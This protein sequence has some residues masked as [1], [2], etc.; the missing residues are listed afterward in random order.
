MS[1]LDS[2]PSA[3]AAYEKGARAAIMSGAK[4]AG[5][6]GEIFW[7]G[8]N[9][10]GPGM[11][12]GLKGDDGQTYWVDE[13]SLGAEDAA[14]PAPAPAPKSDAAPAA[15]GAT[16]DKGDKVTITAGPGSGKI[17]RVFWAGRSK[18]GPGMR[19]GVRDDDDETYWLDGREVA[20]VQ[21]AAGAAVVDAVSPAV[22]GP[23][24]AS[25]ASDK[26]PP[27]FGDDDMLPPEAYEDAPPPE[28][29]DDTVAPEGF[30][31]EPP[32]EAIEGAF[33]GEE[34]F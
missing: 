11:R 6:R 30:V 23:E 24:A 16:F 15:P 18:Y 21:A 13:A 8:E 17:A 22:A 3:Q 19:Y 10:Y 4:G 31:D 25:R 9:K 20:P 14:P 33:G 5:V 7:I 2:K 1:Q 27:V 32:P 28:N 26:A 29:F 34:G 12:Y